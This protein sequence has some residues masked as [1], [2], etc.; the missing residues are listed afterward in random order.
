[1]HRGFTRC[2]GLLPSSHPNPNPETTMLTLLIL[3]P[4]FLILFV[5]TRILRL[6]FVPFRH[7]RY[8]S[9]NRYGTGFNGMTGKGWNRHSPN[10][11]PY[12]RPRFGGLGSILFLVALDRLFGR[13]W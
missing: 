12:A 3:A 7:Y 9:W 8:H 4:I 2:M 11:N 1:M 6:L 13:R 5:V 10:Y